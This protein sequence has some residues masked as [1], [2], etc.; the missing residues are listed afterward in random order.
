MN[1]S[2]TSEQAQS[3]EG[4]Q[5]PRVVQKSRRKLL[6]VLAIVLPLTII[7][8]GMRIYADSQRC[9]DC[10]LDS[11]IDRLNKDAGSSSAVDEETKTVKPESSGDSYKK[12]QTPNP[13]KK[14]VKKINK[15]E[16]RGSSE[17]DDYGVT[18]LA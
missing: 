1:E 15:D 2:I 12:N 6:A 10:D 17:P 8:G 7:G 14:K 18:Q 5:A 16:D 3:E 11:L 9:K 13:K 4:L